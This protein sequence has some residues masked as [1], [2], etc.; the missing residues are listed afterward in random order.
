M[1]MPRV[2]V[3]GEV[4]PDLVL[5]GCATPPILGQ[6]ILAEDFTMTLGGAAALAAMGLAR[7]GTAVA[8]VAKAGPDPWGEFCLDAL[9]ARAVDVSRVVKDPSL[10]TGITVA[11]SMARDRALVTYLGAISSL[12]ADDLE[13]IDLAGFAH[14][15]VSSFFLQPRLRPACRALFARAHG[16][17]LTTSLDPGFDPAQGWDDG[18]RATL[19]ETDLFFPNEVELSAIGGSEAPEDALRRVSNGRTRVVAKL[20]ANGCAT[21]EGDTYLHLPAFSVQPMD[22]TGAG[23]S[24]N[25]GFLHAWLGRRPTRDCLRLGAACGALSTL[26]PGG[27]GSQPTLAEAEALIARGTGA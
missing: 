23:D 10:K 7:L 20:G 5:S 14:V 26:G 12:G 24:F 15:H 27:S 3:V 16:A 17:G 22:T 19:P 6:E 25:A 13:A 2:L 18:L 1:S 8:F 9:R 11:A 4:N 21:L